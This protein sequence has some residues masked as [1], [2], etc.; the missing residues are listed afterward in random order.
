MP[1]LCEAELATSRTKALSA[2]VPGSGRNDL[3]VA[4]VST[5]RL[6]P[7]RSMMMTKARQSNPG[8]GDDSGA[9]VHQL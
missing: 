5:D 4:Q 3:V 7:T 2:I 6:H 9:R 8:I 1:D